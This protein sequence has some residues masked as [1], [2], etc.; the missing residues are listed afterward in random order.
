MNK[1]KVLITAIGMGVTYLMKNKGARDK[2]KN[3][4]Q[5]FT[6]KRH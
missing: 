1:K 2:L 6:K 3:A 5:S 4:V